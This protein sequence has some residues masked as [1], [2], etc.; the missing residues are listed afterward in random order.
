[1]VTW[2]LV[3]QETN[4]PV[5]KLLAELMRKQMSLIM[6]RFSKGGKEKQKW[7]KEQNTYYKV[8]NATI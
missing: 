5:E 8:Y 2:A 6:Q 3:S 7:N 4:Q 1:L